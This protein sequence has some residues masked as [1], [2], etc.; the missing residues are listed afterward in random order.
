MASMGSIMS[1]EGLRQDGRRWNELRRMKCELGVVSG[2]DGSCSFTAGR[3]KVIAS[4]FV[5]PLSK[6]KASAA[7]MPTTATT[8]AAASTTTTTMVMAVMVAVEKTTTTMKIA[9][10]TMMRETKM[11]QV[12][13]REK[14]AGVMLIRPKKIKARAK[15]CT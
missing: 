15:T 4:C 3:T 6:Q 13:G 12:R 10:A 9:A 11:S 8:A 14:R 5:V 1:Y 7:R 2:A